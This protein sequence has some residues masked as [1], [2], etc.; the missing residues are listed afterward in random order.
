MCAGGAPHAVARNFREPG[1]TCTRAALTS[2]RPGA[3]RDRAP[4]VAT[5]APASCA[6]ANRASVATLQ[7]DIII[8]IS[9]EIINLARYSVVSPRVQARKQIQGLF[10]PRPTPAPCRRGPHTSSYCCT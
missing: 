8:E 4:G 7:R 3:R 2:M 6:V 9:Q 10:D 5:K 1:T